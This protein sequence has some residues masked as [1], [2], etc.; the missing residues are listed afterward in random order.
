MR[1]A[2]IAVLALLLISIAHAQTA[3]GNANATASDAQALALAQRSMLALTHGTPISDVTLT[4]TATETAGS[5]VSVGNTTFKALGL[6]NSRVDFD[7]S[8]RSEIRTL[9]QSGHPIGVW[10]TPD[11]K[12]HPMA[13]HNV[14]SDAAWFFPAFSSVSASTQPNVTVKYI[15][16]EIRNGVSVQHLQFFRSADASLAAIATDIP[17]LSKVD[18]YLDST[19][20]LPL[21]ETFNAHPDNDASQNIAMEIDYS[22]YQTVNGMQIPFHVQKLL[23]RGV[24]VDFQVT[25]VSINTGLTVSTFS[26]PQ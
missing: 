9:D 25:Q 20:L 23:S 8:S 7:G 26:I 5:T 4:G 15:G 17:G 12:V 18:I 19:S 22:S 10:I 6:W 24:I 14:W 2:N 3:T 1:H 11:G 16:Q 21:A 13:F